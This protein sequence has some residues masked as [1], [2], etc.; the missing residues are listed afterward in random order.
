MVTR[1]WD[2]W[3]D[4]AVVVDK[5]GGVFVDDTRMHPIDHHGDRFAVAGPLDVP[6]S[7]QG[8]PVR[9][10]AGSSPRGRDFAA[11]HAE[12]IFT[13]QRPR[14]AQE[15]YSDIRERSPRTAATPTA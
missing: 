15:F 2:T 8:H 7:P 1:L 13:A 6:R 11:R 10:Q 14:G 3:D 4:D 12:A 9:V 5:E